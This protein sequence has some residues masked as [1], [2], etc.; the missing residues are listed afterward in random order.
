MTNLLENLG[1]TVGVLGVL[2]CLVTG[3]A[4][5]TGH[6]HVIGYE[7]MTLFT[8]GIALMLI[9]CL[10][11]LQQLTQGLKLANKIQ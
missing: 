3:V 8:G 7:A 2:V 1:N 4:R 6:F 9:A 10:I 5:I 11:K